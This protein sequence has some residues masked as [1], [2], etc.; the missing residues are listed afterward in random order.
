MRNLTPAVESVQEPDGK[1]TA[2]EWRNSKHFLQFMKQPE[3]KQWN[4]EEQNAR[5]DKFVECVES[6]SPGKRMGRWGQQFK[7][8]HNLKE[9]K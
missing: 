7:I 8:F 2:R 6:L 5:G 9:K 4:A 1:M 3:F